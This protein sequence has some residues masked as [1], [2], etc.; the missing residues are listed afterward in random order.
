MFTWAGGEPAYIG[1][2]EEAE[3]CFP[4]LETENELELELELVLALA[5]RLEF[6][7][8]VEFIRLG[9]SFFSFLSFFVPLRFSGCRNNS[10][11]LCAT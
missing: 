7:V 6:F 9:P 3:L 1:G 2:V 4:G 8:F 10:F 5:S 11:K